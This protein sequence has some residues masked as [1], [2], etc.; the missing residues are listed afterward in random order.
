[1]RLRR[2][3]GIIAHI[4]AGKTTLS[5]RILVFTGRKHTAGETH[6]G[7][8]A[9]DYE[10]IERRKGITINAAAT[11]VQWAHS[12]R[13]EVGSINLIDT[14]GHVDFT[15]EVERSLRVLDGA[16]CVLDAKEGVEAQT[17]TVWRQARRYD[18]PCVAFINKMDKRGADFARCCA[19]VSRRLRVATLAVQLPIGAGDDFIGVIDLLSMQALRFEGALGQIVRRE[20]VPAQ[21]L[22]AARQ[23]RRT[24]VEA[25]A[26]LDDETAEAVLAGREPTDLHVAIR[27]VT[28]AGTAVPVLCGAALSN[29]G[30]QP[31]LDAVLD[32]L[33]A[34]EEVPQQ[35]AV[36]VE[37][38]QALRLEPGG[39]AA[40]LVF[41]TVGDDFGTL[42]FTRIFAGQVKQG[43]ALVNAR[44]GHRAR[45][46]RIFRMH[47]DK[48]E[49]VDSAIAG[50]I[51]GLVGLG[52][53]R[54][55]DTL[56]APSR[57]VS[58]EA[59]AF[60]EPVIV[61][62]VEA[63]NNA[64]TG[65]LAE[66]LAARALDDPT[67]RV[68]TD[69]ETSETLVA[70]MGELQLE[71][72]RERL[73][74]MHKVV[75]RFGAPRVAYRESV[76]IA[77]VET[78]G[79]H[80]KQSGGSGSYGHVKI[81][82]S[83]LSPDQFDRIEFVDEVKGGAVP[84][85][86]IR[87]VEAGVRAAAAAGGMAGYPVGGLRAALYDGSSHDVDGKDF[88]F[89]D[90][91]R[92]AFT[93]LLEQA[94]TEI[95]EPVMAVEARV[96]DEF[97]GPVIGDLNSRRGQV[98]AVDADDGISIVRAKVPLAEMFGYVGDLRGMTQGRGTFSMEPAGYEVAPAH[99]KQ[100]LLQ[101]K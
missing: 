89:A 50:D 84:R 5:E 33:P 29:I 61:M 92:L 52:D 1:M 11:H 65:R 45:I 36:L 37:S 43:D 95:L 85:Q 86:F 77:G 27:R 7:A 94:G 63:E 59:I 39:E 28:V 54:T 6:N 30:V 24:L 93:A 100:Q 80:R 66:A 71:V 49:S 83:S 64:D 55:G 3:I 68:R 32:Y 15:A 72:L 53:V 97:M 19:D 60:P 2:N 38:G 91:A 99:V 46:G 67:L 14:P 35:Q 12:L 13:G 18:V 75:A 8:S 56:S 20:D 4:D 22:Q 70:G 34:P 44:T 16:V 73:A 69:P 57:V 47:A 76:A 48:R 74:T 17:E 42:S 78:E 81:R 90:A 31:V 26:N 58:L 88:A 101:Q 51:V 62:S 79:L 21:V 23:A 40:A 41:K 10:D 82:W 98:H 87:H 96:P 25:L 9:L